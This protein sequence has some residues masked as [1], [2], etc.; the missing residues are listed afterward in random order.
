[1]KTRH[2]C[3]LRK[4]CISFGNTVDGIGGSVLTD[5]LDLDTLSRG[6]FPLS[7]SSIVAV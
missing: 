4:F 6:G 5:A 2:R 3:P 1:V 7:G